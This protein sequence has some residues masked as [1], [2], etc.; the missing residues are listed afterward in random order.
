[1]SASS[2]PHQDYEFLQET[3]E[4][5]WLEIYP[6]LENKVRNPLHAEW[7][8]EILWIVNAHGHNLS[9][10]SWG[11][12]NADIVQQKILEYT[13]RAW[14][15]LQEK[16][17]HKKI[18]FLLKQYERRYI[19]ILPRMELLDT[20]FAISPI[21]MSSPYQTSFFTKMIES[22]SRQLH[23]LGEYLYKNAFYEACQP[24][25]ELGKK[26]EKFQEDLAKI[27]SQILDFSIKEILFPQ[28]CL[29]ACLSSLFDLY[30]TSLPLFPWMNDTTIYSKVFEMAQTVQS[31]YPVLKELSEHDF[32]PIPL[33]QSPVFPENT[34]EKIVWTK[35][36]LPQGGKPLGIQPCAWQFHNKIWPKAERESIK[37]I[38]EWYKETSNPLIYKHILE[39]LSVVKYDVSSLAQM[40]SYNSSVEMAKE[41]FQHFKKEEN[42]EKLDTI[43]PFLSAYGIEI[44]SK[45]NAHEYLEEDDLLVHE[46]SFGE[47]K[48]DFLVQMGARFSDQKFQTGKYVHVI[49]KEPACLSVLARMKLFLEKNIPSPTIPSSLLKNLESFFQAEFW[50]LAETK[51]DFLQEKLYLTL[52]QVIQEADS[53]LYTELTLFS[54]K[55]RIKYECLLLELQRSLREDGWKIGIVAG[56][57]RSQEQIQK[58]SQWEQKW[59]KESPSPYLFLKKENHDYVAIG[60]PFPHE[61]FCR[62]IVSEHDSTPGNMS[63]TKAMEPEILRK[64]KDFFP[65]RDSRSVSIEYQCLSLFQKHWP[66]DKKK[67][68]EGLL[69]CL[70]A[71]IP[72]IHQDAIEKINQ[73]LALDNFPA[74]LPSPKILGEKWPALE[75]QNI[76][77]KEGIEYQFCEEK[78]K[79]TV[80]E[81]LSFGFEKSQI[82]IR[83]SLGKCDEPLCL[84]WEILG[85]FSYLLKSFVFLQENSQMPI[86]PWPFYPCSDKEKIIEVWPCLIKNLIPFEPEEYYNLF[87]L[88]N[89]FS[90]IEKYKKLLSLLTLADML[91]GLFYPESAEYQSL[92]DRVAQFLDREKFR[93]MPVTL[94][95]ASGNA[96]IRYLLWPE[97]KI[98][99]IAQ[100]RVLHRNAPAIL[101]YGNP[102]AV[103]EKYCLDPFS[104]CLHP[105]KKIFLVFW[106]AL[107]RI[108]TSHLREQAIQRWLAVYY[109]IHAQ[110]QIHNVIEFLNAGYEY[111]EILSS[112]LPYDF[113]HQM[114]SP[115]LE[116]LQSEGFSIIHAAKGQIYQN[117][118][119]L[120][121]D[122]E[123]SL[124]T[125]R[126]KSG[127]IL[128]TKRPCILKKDK[129]ELWQKGKV[130]VVL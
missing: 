106:A 87:I 20:L 42:R 26:I 16:V 25:K 53:I 121:F 22:L 101:I 51:R 3:F 52:C 38:I 89:G 104:S 35:V 62:Y 33:I 91:V 73:A 50:H 44:V 29:G 74:L 113:V 103:S 85:F 130:I 61:R 93:L 123:D 75:A 55:N 56:K 129:E 95:H 23:S 84:S 86:S 10:M 79:N 127:T 58:L 116:F 17:S 5:I 114:F 64:W 71:L 107:Q 92:C 47:T 21:T 102:A 128:Y 39:K 108:T 63:Y 12:R 111:Q 109:Q 119:S 98:L 60:F 7:K 99:A 112:S 59:Y 37:K 68:Q 54:K 31:S 90:S 94:N 48:S 118:D 27:K 80:L 110:P 40:F 6:I 115:I 96:Q 45:S 70:D 4:S 88:Q 81:I 9:A 100:R 67:V 8:K 18:S 28:N 77:C 97:N 34:L 105:L 36:F 66:T 41:I 126:E 120:Y 69:S 1:M 65:S 15:S 46:Y 125:H 19:E 78:E 14:N 117:E 13:L 57:Y 72:E 30:H 49:G 122:K 83:A 124:L 82:K 76:L 32:L 2:I 24:G 11:Y 43:Q